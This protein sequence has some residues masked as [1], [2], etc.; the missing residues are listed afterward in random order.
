MA[1]IFF[2]SDTHFGHENI[3]KFCPNTRP[4]KTIEEHDRAIIANWQAQVQPED[5]VYHLGDVMFCNEQRGFNILSQLPG[6]KYLVW[7]NHDK[8]VANSQR[9]KNLF[10]GIDNYREIKIEG[11]P[12]VLFHFP[13]FEW[14]K[15]HHGSFHFYGHVHGNSTV[16]GRAQDVGIDPRG[17]DMKLWTWEELY[18]KLKDVPERT[19]HGKTKTDMM[20]ASDTERYNNHR[21]QRTM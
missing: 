8:V 5:V 11:H 17:G 14:N 4:F 12:I 10:V 9:I 20:E 18:A 15:M 2:T 19:H 6:Q 1:R 7:G 3:L 16:P 13:I 21:S